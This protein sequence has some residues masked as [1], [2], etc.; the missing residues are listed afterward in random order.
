MAILHIW[1]SHDGSALQWRKEREKKIGDHPMEANGTEIIEIGP[2]YPAKLV[3]DLMAPHFFGAK[4]DRAR[5]FFTLPQVAV[6]LT[7]IIQKI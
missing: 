2:R 4:E 3:S 6:W 7:I 1:P 5:R